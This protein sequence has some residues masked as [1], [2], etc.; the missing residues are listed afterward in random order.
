MRSNWFLQVSDTNL[1]CGSV[2]LGIVYPASYD[3]VSLVDSNLFRV[4]GCD[5]GSADAT[6]LEANKNPM[7]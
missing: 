6:N 7:S 3:F 2:V 1:I 4:F 5:P